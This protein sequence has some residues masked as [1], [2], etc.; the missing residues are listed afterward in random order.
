MR[1]VPCGRGL[2]PGGG[3]GECGGGGG[4][5]GGPGQTGPL[6]RGSSEVSV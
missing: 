4:K 5:G 3:G 2:M 6:S 1:D